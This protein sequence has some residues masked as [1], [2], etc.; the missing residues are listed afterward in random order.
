MI[1]ANL[2]HFCSFSDTIE[3]KL[4]N[5][6]KIKI[7]YFIQQNIKRGCISMA[8]DILYYTCPAYAVVMVRKMI[9]LTDTI[10]D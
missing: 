6:Q 10:N 2:S 3:E 9:C 1:N 7:W 8:E 5:S 4:A